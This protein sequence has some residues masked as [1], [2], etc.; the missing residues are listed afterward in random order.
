M[1]K[2]KGKLQTWF[3]NIKGGTIL[4]EYKNLRFG[5][6][7]YFLKQMQYKLG[8]N[9]TILKKKINFTTLPL[10]HKK[11]INLQAFW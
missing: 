8:S 1:G 10:Y 9:S 4:I 6:S 7:N 11:K 5:R 3:T 2:G